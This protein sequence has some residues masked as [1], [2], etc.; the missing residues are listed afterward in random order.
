[1][2]ATGLLAP[3]LVLTTLVER[4]M[5]I[6]G[7][8]AERGMVAS[9]ELLIRNGQDQAEKDR[10]GRDPNYVR[11]LLLDNAGY[12][13]RKRV[14]TFIIGSA[15]GML[16]SV[17]TG[18]R[19]FEMTFA[20]LQIP[21]PVAYL[22][23]IDLVIVFDIIVTGMILGAGSQPAHSIINWI[24][25]AQSVQSEV[26]QLRKGQRTL[27]DAEVLKQILVTL[28]LPADLLNHV[29][30]LMQRN[31]VST[32]DDLLRLLHGDTTRATA[33]AL[34]AAEAAVRLRSYLA[35]AG[36]SDLLYLVP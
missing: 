25:F 34:D 5:E 36:R 13:D 1:M 26:S 16:L 6:F 12:K 21:Q 24:Y 9:K 35:D 33:D 4:V 15:L 7:D 19:F 14:V 10:L 31:G 32:L 30:E 17:F 29:F 18:V 20:V 2:D 22:G 11:K 3:I 28:G 8:L 23:K 27:N